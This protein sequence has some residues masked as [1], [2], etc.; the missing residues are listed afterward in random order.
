MTARLLLAFVALAAGVVAVVI[1]ALLLQST[2]GP[3]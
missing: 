3:Q 1:V 2:P